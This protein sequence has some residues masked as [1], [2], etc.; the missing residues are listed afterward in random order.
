MDLLVL[1]GAVVAGALA[2]LVGSFLH[3]AT[4]AG[5]PTGLLLALALSGAAVVAPALALGS[6]AAALLAVGGWVATALYA[7]VRRPEGDLLVQADGVGYAWLYGGTV[8]LAALA[9]AV[10]RLRPR[11]EP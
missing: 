3:A 4:V 6:S 9:A 7:S 8:L 5:L 2:A 1:V 10:H 11:W